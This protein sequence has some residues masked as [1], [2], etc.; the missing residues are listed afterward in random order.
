MQIKTLNI[1]LR[2]HIRDSFDDGQLYQFI[3]SLTTKYTCKI[4]IHTWNIRRSNVSW[5]EMKKDVSEIT[6]VGIREYFRDLPVDKILIDD[7]QHVHLHGSRVGRIGASACPTISWKYYWYGQKRVTE[8]IENPDSLVLNMRFDMFTGPFNPPIKVH[9]GL[10]FVERN[11]SQDSSTT[12]NFIHD[13]K[14]IWGLDNMYLGP[15]KSLHSLASHFH[16]NL[17]KILQNNGYIHT[18]HQEFLVLF[19]CRRLGL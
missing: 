2:G 16:L 17:D 9:E 14:F 1:A 10:A 5:R 8:A 11:M 3:K 6:E 12:I 19:E 18:V 4:F 15:A 7:D 13:N